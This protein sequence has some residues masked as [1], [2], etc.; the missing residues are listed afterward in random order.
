[1]GAKLSFASPGSMLVFAAAVLAGLIAGTLF[2]AVVLLFQSPWT[3]MEA[4]AAAQH[5]GQS[6]TSV[7][8]R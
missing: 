4:T 5:A 7:A 6:A 3:P 1:M 8:Q 2:S